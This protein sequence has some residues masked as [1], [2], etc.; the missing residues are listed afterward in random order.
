[1]PGLPFPHDTSRFSVARIA[2]TLRRGK[3]TIR[4]FLGRDGARTHR[5]QTDHKESGSFSALAWSEGNNKTIVVMAQLPGDA[6]FTTEQN[7]IVFTTDA[8]AH[9]RYHVSGAFTYAPVPF[10][11][12]VRKL[13]EK[14]VPWYH[15]SAEA[16]GANGIRIEN[17]WVTLLDA[18][19]R[20][21]TSA[22]KPRLQFRV[23]LVEAPDVELP[24]D[25]F[26][27]TREK[28][29]GDPKRIEHVLFKKLKPGETVLL[30]GQFHA[31]T[32]DNNGKPYERRWIR[33][34]VVDR[35]PAPPVQR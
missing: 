10:R 15:K 29:S 8:G 32:F 26:N 6:Q 17:T 34:Y 27:D 21:D 11:R 7:T 28:E 14:D 3:E 4:S 33:C 30:T 18:P 13:E 16:F 31:D 35:L 24:V 9:I 1:L 25:V 20:K 23:K 2:H 12:D 5:L 22:G 19:A